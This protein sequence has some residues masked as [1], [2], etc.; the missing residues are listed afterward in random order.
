MGPDI[1]VAEP[2][3]AVVLLATMLLA[4]MVR[5]TRR[6]S[7][8][9]AIAQ[10]RWNTEAAIALMTTPIAESPERKVIDLREPST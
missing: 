8:L 1:V 9:A 5:R 10:Q 3:L 4:G 6:P 2:A 7:R